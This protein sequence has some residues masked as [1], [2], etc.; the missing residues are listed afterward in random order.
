MS[1]DLTLYRTFIEGCERRA[2]SGIDSMIKEFLVQYPGAT[3]EEVQ[4]FTWEAVDLQL[5]IWGDAAAERSLEMF[6]EVCEREG[7]RAVSRRYDVIDQDKV[8]DA[9]HYARTL[10]LEKMDNDQAGYRK[11]CRTLMESYVHRSAWD[12][13]IRNC[14]EN[15]IRWARVPTG[16]E[17]CAWCLML[18][19]RGFDYLSSD[20]ARAGN[21]NGCDCMVVP[22]KK[23]TDI[24]GYDPDAM[25]RSFYQM[26]DELDLD[27]GDRDVLTRSLDRMSDYMRLKDPAWVYQGKAASYEVAEGAD[28]NESE[29]A[30]AVLLGRSGLRVVFQPVSSELGARRPDSLIA[31][32][33]WEM[34]NPTGNGFLLVRNQFKSAVFGGRKNRVFNPQADRLI[35]SNVESPATFEKLVAGAEA[36]ARRDP[37]VWM[38][39]FSAIKEVIIVDA[40]GSGRIRLIK[41]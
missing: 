36:L 25:A 26:A 39:E 2:A 41:I 3:P 30:C 40:K 6:D 38:D 12:N 35:I 24:E 22:G 23:G 33:P 20:T 16:S 31:S 32:E 34:K 5:G 1:L 9:L 14:E 28:P 37:D 7:I 4:A 19:S 21:H 8:A 29:K 27:L 15:R 11:R 10:H 13:V 18:A 17:T